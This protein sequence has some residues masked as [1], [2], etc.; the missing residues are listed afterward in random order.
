MGTRR[1]GRSLPAGPA[2]TPHASSGWSA[3]ACATILAR[4]PAEMISMPASVTWRL[5]I[6]PALHGPGS[7]ARLTPRKA[8]QHGVAGD[9]AGPGHGGRQGPLRRA[10]TGAIGHDMDDPAGEG[11]D[12][13]AHQH[14]GGARL[15]RSLPLAGQVQPRQHGQAPRAGTPRQPDQDPGGDE[16]AAVAELA[17][18]QGAAVML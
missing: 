14:G 16:A 18:A 10:V 15:A 1:S 17:H 7:P 5:D 3:R 8:V 9:A 2:M 11:Q 4:S 6:L 13:Q 12:E